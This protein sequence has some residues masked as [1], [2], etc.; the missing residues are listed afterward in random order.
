MLWQ[1]DC[2]ASTFESWK[3]TKFQNIVANAQGLPGRRV[4][5]S[6]EGFC[7][8]SQTWPEQ[9]GADSAKVIYEGCKQ[10]C[11]FAQQLLRETL[12][13]VFDELVKQF[14]TACLQGQ[15][16]WKAQAHRNFMPRGAPADFW[17][18]AAAHEVPHSKMQCLESVSAACNA[19]A[20][21]L[22]SCRSAFNMANLMQSI[23]QVQALVRSQTLSADTSLNDLCEVIPKLA[24]PCQTLATC[25]SNVPS[26]ASGREEMLADIVRLV[27]EPLSGPVLNAFGAFVNKAMESALGSKCLKMFYHRLHGTIRPFT[28]MTLVQI[29]SINFIRRQDVT[30]FNV[31]QG[32]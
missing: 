18:R 23:A 1:C 26:N 7:K 14:K 10:V 6:I 32:S 8:A 13:T 11:D 21:Q 16:W 20:D 12:P 30:Y 22:A 15:E 9:L 2:H 4:V 24:T 31:V 19:S 27:V 17:V 29:K 5:E 3:S 28:T 25:L